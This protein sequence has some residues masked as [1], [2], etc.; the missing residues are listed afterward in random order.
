M[1]GVTEDD[2]ILAVTDRTLKQDLR[3]QNTFWDYHTSSYKGTGCGIEH[4][5]LIDFLMGIWGGVA[6]AWRWRALVGNFVIEKEV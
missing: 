1:D 4:P 5:S 3:F 6:L 2:N